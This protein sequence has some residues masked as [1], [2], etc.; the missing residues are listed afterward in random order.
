MITIYT[1]VHKINSEFLSDLS[2]SLLR[3]TDHDFEWIVLLNGEA[4]SEIEKLRIKF[5]WAKILSTDNTGNIGALKAMCCEKAQGDILVELDYDDLLEPNAVEEIKKAFKNPEVVFA[6][7]NSVH[8]TGRLADRQDNV[9]SSAFGWRWR[10][11]GPW[12]EQIAFPESVQYMRRIEWAPNH[13]RAFR[14]SAYEAIG[15]YDQS[16]EV[17]DDHDLVCRFYKAFGQNGFK[18]ID[19]PLYFYRV[20]GGNTCN[21][22]NRNRDVQEQVDRNYI[23][24]AEDMYKRWA[25]DNG[26]RCYDLGGRFNSP[27]GYASVDLL[28]A[29]VVA[30]LNVDWPFPDD[31]VGVLRAYHILEHLDDPIHFFNEA[32]R[33]LAPGGFLLIEVPSVNGA[34]AFADPTHKKF[35]NLLSFEYYTNE[36]FARYIR[37][38][39]KGRFQKARLTEYWWT[40]PNIPIISAQ[41]IAL[42]GW[43]DE[44]WCGLREI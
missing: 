26:L 22:S 13:V 32:Y 20:H 39:Y 12:R 9:F 4:V 30:D 5:P 29:D 33:V 10:Q 15:G 43:Y 8:F 23:A 3:Q 35:F 42:K 34:G 25:S 38:Q 7:S 41:L 18:H 36:R 31:S 17:G 2:S 6:Y 19:K 27:S 44:R 14:K 28:D 21:G 1:P 11:Y 24:H 37:P 16:L 40:N